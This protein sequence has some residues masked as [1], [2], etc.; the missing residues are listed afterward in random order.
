VGLT[1]F[2]IKFCTCNMN[3]RILHKILLVPHNIVL[4]L[5][6]CMFPKILYYCIPT[7]HQVHVATPRPCHGVA[8]NSSKPKLVKASNNL[9]LAQQD[10]T[11]P[12]PPPKACFDPSCRPTPCWHCVV[13]LAQT[14]FTNSTTCTHMAFTIPRFTISIEQD[15]YNW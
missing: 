7:M 1:I 8:F 14:H 13:E 9:I 5:N 2:Y 3:V 6:I 10:P 4:D 12:T 11:Q 15:D